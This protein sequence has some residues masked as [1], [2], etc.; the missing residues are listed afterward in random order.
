[1]R[2][3]VLY[4]S[5]YGFTKEIATTLRNALGDHAA[6]YNLM[7]ET[8]MLEDYEGL[9][10]GTAVYMGKG[11]KEVREFIHQ[12]KEALKH[13]K[14]WLFLSGANGEEL[15]KQLEIC[16]TKALVEVSIFSTHVGYK[17]DR[18]KMSILD[19]LIMKMVNKDGSDNNDGVDEVALDSLIHSIN[20]EV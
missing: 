4:G 11:R 12:N 6:I 9:V 19:K 15:N 8:P 14:I 2:V 1:M 3:A 5:K 16:F 18:E 10:I 20:N 7:E 17:L 13:K